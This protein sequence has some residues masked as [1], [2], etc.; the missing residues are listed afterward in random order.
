[1][2]IAAGVRCEDG[3]LLCADT[4][5]SVS[6]YYKMGQSKLHFLNTKSCR[7]FFAAAGDVDFTHRALEVI[8]LFLDECEPELAKVK[9]A[10]DNACFQIVDTWGSRVS[11]PLQMIGVI[12]V[13][14]SMAEFVKIA[15]YLVSPIKGGFSVIG[16]GEPLAHFLFSRGQLP[17]LGR[18]AA[19]R[20]AA[21]VLY[22]VK[23]TV[24]GCG[25]VTQFLFVNKDGGW[26]RPF[27]NVWSFEFLKEL[28]ES[29]YRLDLQIQKI[30]PAVIN[31]AML[32]FPQVID[33]IK[34]HIVED[35]T[36]H[37]KKMG[38]R[39]DAYIEQEIA[40]AEESPVDEEQSR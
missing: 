17:T 7:A 20:H 11:D 6:G 38:D 35:R 3:F 21:Y 22:N 5:V 31:Y 36:Q 32:D 16:S 26:H 37:L 13:K 10:L 9:E 39:E 27:E 8:K 33:G 14:G 1:M 2:T 25:G 29:F 15:G 4:L 12:S 30:V 19:I 28:E 23:R 24:D 18:S 40:K 34:Q